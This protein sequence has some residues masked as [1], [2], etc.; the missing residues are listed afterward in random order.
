MG[1]LPLVGFSSHMVAQGGWG[2]GGLV[3]NP[4]NGGSFYKTGWHY[5]W[6]KKSCTT[7]DTWNYVNNGIN[8]FSTGAGFLPSTVGMLLKCLFFLQQF[9][10]SSL[11]SQCFSMV[12]LVSDQTHSHRGDRSRATWGIVWFR[13]SQS[14]HSPMI[15]WECFG[16]VRWNTFPVVHHWWWFI[17]VGFF[18]FVAM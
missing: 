9:W 2:V 17:Y 10:T 14:H 1:P 15:S 5:C 8:Y 12:L 18:L 3:T 6:W 4:L 16:W 7:C 11:K 13:I